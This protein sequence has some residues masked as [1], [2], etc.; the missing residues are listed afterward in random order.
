LDRG[1]SIT[2]SIAISSA[3]SLS[4]STPEPEPVDGFKF[5][6]TLNYGGDPDSVR[7]PRKFSDMVDVRINQV[8]LRV[9]GGAIGLWTAELLFNRTGTPYLASGWRKFCQRHKIV[10]GLWTAELLFN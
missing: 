2:I 3:L 4:P 7:L 10:A 9:S 5:G 8:L 6:V 1:G